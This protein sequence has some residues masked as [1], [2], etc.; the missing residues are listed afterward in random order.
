MFVYVHV[1]YNIYDKLKLL[2]FRQGDTQTEIII[3]YYNIF[4]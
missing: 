2:T 3:Y 1:I 4:W